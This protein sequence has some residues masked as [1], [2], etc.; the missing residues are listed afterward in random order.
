MAEP[1]QPPVPPQPPKLQIKL[2]ET[3]AHGVYTNMVL[4]HSNDSEFT[5][6]FCFVQPHQPF[7]SVRSRVITSPRHIKRFLKILTQQLDR[8]EKL[9]G[10]LGPLTPSEAESSYH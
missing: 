4:I 8:W 10:E 1:Q 5:L 2:D 9:H 7:A 6:D 3:T